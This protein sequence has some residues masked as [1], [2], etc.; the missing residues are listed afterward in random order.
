MNACARVRRVCAIVGLA[1]AASLPSR[2]SAEDGPHHE[3]DSLPVTHT[4]ERVK[5][6]PPAGIHV[7]AAGITVTFGGFAKVDLIQDFDPIGNLDQF[8]VNSI[9]IDGTPAAGVGGNNNISARQTRFSL[10]VRGDESSGH[11]RA[12]VEGDFFGDAN[13]FRM[14][15]GYGEWRGLL[16]G[17]TWSTF[18]DITARPPTLDYEGPD[19]EVFV[20]QP[21]LR[22]TRQ[23]SDAFEWSIAVEDQNSQL[24]LP[25]GATGGGRS[26]MPDVPARVR[27][28]SDRG[29]IQLAGIV[30]QLRYVSDGG[31][32]KEQTIAFGG[33][34][35]AKAKLFGRDAIMG[36]VAAGSGLGR[37]IEAF[38]GTGSDALLTADGEL[39]ALNSF[40]AVLAYVHVWSDRLQSSV[41]GGIATV[42]NQ[43]DQ[44]DTAIAATRSAH[45]NLVYSP[46][47]RVSLGGELMWGEREDKDDATGSATRFQFSVQ[48]KFK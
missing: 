5:D 36:H 47:Q 3:H 37:Y 29:H 4:D 25:G 44:P 13:A 30:R 40:A 34:L 19:A 35:S 48:Y 22:Y 41:A 8:K 12:Y 14:R 6:S 23:A 39:E 43:D 2:A 46:N 10:D 45:A 7:E 9:P 21:M 32:T 20:R 33:N 38:G 24:T 31:G 26:A 27:L 42:D 16:G 15:H 18:Q 11:F 17:Q 1:L 28:Q